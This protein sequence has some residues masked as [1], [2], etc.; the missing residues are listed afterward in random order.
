MAVLGLAVAAVVLWS[1]SP[2]RPL[3]VALYPFVPDKAGL[4]RLVQESVARAHPDIDLRIVDLSDNYYDQDAP[5][6]ITN[7]D[8]DVLEVDSVLIQDL[9][10]AHRIQPLPSEIRAAGGRMLR[11][12]ADAV[13]SGSGWY[14][15][16]HW[17]CTNFL[18]ADAQDPLAH[19]ATLDDV[20]TAIGT[21]RPPGHGLLI[22]LEGRLTLGELYLD[23]LLDKYRTLE[24]ADPFVPLAHRDEAVVGD[25][26]RVRQLCDLNLCRDSAYH[27]SAAFYARLFAR[28]EGRALAGYSERLHDIADETM[29]GCQRGQ[30]RDLN[31][32]AMVP[33]PLSSNGSQPFAWVDSFAVSQGC[34]GACLR[35]ALAFIHETTSVDAVRLQLTPASGEAPRYLMPALEDL[36]SDRQ[37]LAAAPLYPKLHPAV[38]HAIAVREAGL[39]KAL[40]EMGSRLDKIDLPR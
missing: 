7:A 15:V 6:G 31:Q 19:A 35:D 26:K 21:T 13:A 23:A 20:V 27:Q 9:I 37:L 28:R 30:C 5:G 32:I 3:R 18:F 38:E 2:R 16:P 25:L 33:L 24:T 14:G 12:A 8:A 17:V 29:N 22:D 11:V 34:T 40:R 39:N 36:Y 1:P 4:F 10:D